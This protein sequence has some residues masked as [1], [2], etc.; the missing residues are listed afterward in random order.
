MRVKI[1]QLVTESM[2]KSQINQMLK[3]RLW[4]AQNMAARQTRFGM[5]LVSALVLASCAGTQSDV[6]PSASQTQAAETM[7][8]Q[9]EQAEAERMAA[10]EARQQAERRER[11]L[12]AEVD[13]LAREEA[14]AEAAR[15]QAEREAAQARREAEERRRRQQARAEQEARIAAQEERINE[16]ETQIAS[17]DAMIAEQE[18]TN[19][20]LR[21]AVMAAEDLL[22]ALNVEQEKYDNVDT[23]GEPIAPLNKARLSELESRTNQLINA[24]QSR[25]Q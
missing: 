10:E 1:R 25:S 3:P 22:R 11:V 2:G 8:A 15:E 6:G 9:V 17:Y 20:R 7:Q 13:R 23:S 18:E 19:A 12:Q 24:A 16:L 14:A 5:A 21:D 4:L